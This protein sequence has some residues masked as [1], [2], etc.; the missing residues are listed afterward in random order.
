MT[1]F[2][3]VEFEFTKQCYGFATK[4]DAEK[5]VALTSS[6]RG[7]EL[8]GWEYVIRRVPAEN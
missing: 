5:F 8:E 6:A 2:W 7:A 4:T 3:L 1:P